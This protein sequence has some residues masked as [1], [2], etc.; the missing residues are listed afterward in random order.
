[1]FKRFVAAQ[2]FHTSDT[3]AGSLLLGGPFDLALFWDLFRKP[4]DKF[5]DPGEIAIAALALHVLGPIFTQRGLKGAALSAVVL[6]VAFSLMDGR[7]PIGGA[8]EAQ[9][10]GDKLCAQIGF[11]IWAV[12]RAVIWTGQAV[13]DRLAS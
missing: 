5:E 11:G 3:V 7:L 8:T 12:S 10:E 2:P 4:S 1:M 13:L 9:R 6:P